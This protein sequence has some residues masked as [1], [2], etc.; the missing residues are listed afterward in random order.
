MDPLRHPEH[1]Q[2][3]WVNAAPS[4]PGDHS[5]HPQSTFYPTQ[6]YYPPPMSSAFPSDV[7]AGYFKDERLP[8]M[9][10]SE[11]STPQ[12]THRPS[13]NN[14]PY[15]AMRKPRAHRS[16]GMYP[17]E[18]GPKFTPTKCLE[19]I[20][21]MDHTTVLTPTIQGKMD[22]F[23]FTDNDWTCYRRNYFQVSCGFT[24]PGITFQTVQPPGQHH[25]HPSHQHH[26][27]PG[28][29]PGGY[30][31]PHA[32]ANQRAFYPP[33]PF[34]APP[35][36]QEPQCYIRMDGQDV[37]IHQFCL[38][39]SAKV[40]NSDKKI[41]LVQHTPKRDKGPQ[42]T[43]KPRPVLPSNSSLNLSMASGA[44]GL[45]GGLQSIVTFERIQ[46]KTATAN[47]GKR[48]AA[49]QYY[50]C[51]MDLYVDVFLDGIIRQIKVASCHSEPL[52][53]RGRSPGHYSD[54]QQQQ[55]VSRFQPSPYATHP[56]PMGINPTASTDPAMAAYPSGAPPPPAYAGP[57][58]SF[59][60]P[61]MMLNT[62]SPHVSMRPMPYDYPTS[63][64]PSASSTQP[65]PSTHPY[66]I[67]NMA[68]TPT[69]PT[70]ATTPSATASSSSSVPSST[71]L[72]DQHTTSSISPTT[73][74]IP[75]SYPTTPNST[76]SNY[77]SYFHNPIH[78]TTPTLSSTLPNHK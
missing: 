56:Y 18:V 78:A 50:V 38:S 21:N 68:A 49:Q 2:E 13:V 76:S 11:P 77:P 75:A 33:P 24:L 36:H 8:D 15:P 70:S 44:M 59:M 4:K 27:V 66:M 47:N 3:D 60:Q 48:R 67:P 74:G 16:D 10:P 45:S 46:F 52:V 53:V 26:L 42:S 58:S 23:F 63:P 5:S 29:P 20:Y 12:P 32:P 64:Q 1:Q 14:D 31:D 39:I 55:N 71:V 25:H 40:S 43:P 34:P 69:T 7:P 35:P 28:M 17:S 41:D 54:H 65:S 62:M 6:N 72:A 30:Y 19:P 61:P 22:R 51:L 9:M 37:Q 73:P 57:P